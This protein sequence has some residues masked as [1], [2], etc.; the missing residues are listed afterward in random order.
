M[1]KTKICKLLIAS[2]VVGVSVTHGVTFKAYAQTNTP[3]YL[4]L[5][6]GQTMVFVGGDGTRDGGNVAPANPGSWRGGT[7]LQPWGSIHYGSVS[8]LARRVG[9]FQNYRTLAA[10]SFTGTNSSSISVTTSGSF[11]VMAVHRLPTGQTKPSGKVYAKVDATAHAWGGGALLPSVVASG[12]VAVTSLSAK[13]GSQSGTPSATDPTRVTTSKKGLVSID[14]SNASKQSG[15]SDIYVVETQVNNLDVSATM[16]ITKRAN[17]DA[18]IS[19]S[20]SASAVLDT[21]SISLSRANAHDEWV[22]DGVKHGD[23]TYSHYYIEDTLAK[24]QKE[25]YNN[26]SFSIDFSGQWKNGVQDPDVYWNW[27]IDEGKFAPSLLGRQKRILNGYISKF[28]ALVDDQASGKWQGVAQPTSD[29]I[30]FKYFARDNGDQAEAEA[31]YVLH[32]R[33]PIET[34]SAERNGFSIAVDYFD[35]SGKPHLINELTATHTAGNSWSIVG[36]IGTESFGIP[37]GIEVG[38]ETST[39]VE[40]SKTLAAY[41]GPLG[42]NEYVNAMKSLNYNR[43]HVLFWKYD[44]GGKNRRLVAPIGPP[45]AAG[46]QTKDL[47]EVPQ[48]TIWTRFSNWYLFWSPVK[49]RDEGGYP[50]VTD[51]Q[52]TPPPP[53][54]KYSR[55]EGKKY[56]KP[57]L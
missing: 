46:W 9:H 3:N 36:T 30:T 2:L 31:R 54:F 17:V 8:D 19:S 53:S 5:S 18:V 48:E 23:T 56:G 24:I 50:E 49:R 15:E 42:P 52:P 25:R 34:V 14:L 55:K 16:A 29:S 22:E 43:H 51:P 12:Q 39:S 47:V 38:N 21:R 20:S 33:E 35:S 57:A 6:P 26:Q 10:R 28:G 44:A 40:S 13:V 37:L 1:Q 7:D 45:P 4:N 11:K 27:V 41:A 32:L